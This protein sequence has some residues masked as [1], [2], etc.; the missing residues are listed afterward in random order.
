MRLPA[1][2]IQAATALAEDVERIG[3]QE[4]KRLVDHDAVVML[5]VSKQP[6]G[7]K[8]KGA[9]RANPNDLT[10]WLTVVLRGKDMITY[11]TLTNEGSSARAARLLKDVGIT[12]A[13]ALRGGLDAWRAAG[14]PLGELSAPHPTLQRHTWRLSWHQEDWT[15]DWWKS[16]HF[17]YPWE[18]LSAHSGQMIRVR[19]CSSG[20]SD[21]QHMYRYSH[22]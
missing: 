14:F 15:E 4:A 13:K 8:I 22:R 9:V 10:G 18:A 17:K 1:A 7:Q 11:C 21:S 20:Y 5:D 19:T 6:Q 12:A 16:K 3:P 2:D